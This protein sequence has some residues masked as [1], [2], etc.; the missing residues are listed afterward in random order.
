M[1]RQE[2]I[3]QLQQEIDA[4]GSQRRS[5]LSVEERAVQRERLNRL[6]AHIDVLSLLDEYEA[7]IE[8]MLYEVPMQQIGE[9]VELFGYTCKTLTETLKSE[10]APQ[11]KKEKII[12][13]SDRKP[14]ESS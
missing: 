14:D 3:T 8:T 1:S 13:F 9:F 12:S 6:K 2:K 5:A 7:Y 4:I 11:H 10:L